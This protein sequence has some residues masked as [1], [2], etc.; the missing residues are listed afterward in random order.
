MSFPVC[1]HEGCDKPVGIPGVVHGEPRTCW[2]RIL[3]I[4]TPPTQGWQGGFF[5]EGN[6]AVKTYCHNHAREAH[7]V[8]QVETQSPPVP[9]HRRAVA[10]IQALED[11]RIFEIL[12]Q[13]SVEYAVPE[14]EQRALYEKWTHRS[15]PED[16]PL[17]KTLDHEQHGQDQAPS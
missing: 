16:E 9:W 6:R 8:H 12:D 14:A 13:V 2:Q 11:Q 17:D 1:D 15:W 4:E 10:E 5:F 7:A 3:G